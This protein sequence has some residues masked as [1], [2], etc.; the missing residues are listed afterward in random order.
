M[1]VFETIESRRSIRKYKGDPVPAELLEKLLEAARLAPSASNVQSWK[2]K[3]VSDAETRGK[4]KEAAAGQKFVEQA[5]VVIACCIDFGAFKEKGKQTLK[6]VTTGAVKP[7][8]G[9]IL[10]AVRGSQEK[11]LDAERLVIHGVINVTIATEHI[12]LAAAALGLGTCW[13]RAFDA[14]RA[15]QILGLPEDVT[16]LALLTVGYPDEAPPARPRR[17]LEE[18]LL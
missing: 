5:P 9:M 1:E 7:S 16:V 8:I 14:G 3:V 15:E 11:G 10:R 18:I 2:F 12:V 4:L 13:I 17:R 6:L